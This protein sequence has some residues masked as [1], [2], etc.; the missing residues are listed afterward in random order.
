MEPLKRLWCIQLLYSLCQDCGCIS[1]THILC[2]V[3]NNISETTVH[4]STIAI[5]GIIFVPALKVICHAKMISN[6]LTKGESMI[7]IKLSTR[8]RTQETNVMYL[9]KPKSDCDNFCRKMIT[10]SSSIVWGILKVMTS[11]FFK[12]FD[13]YGFSTYLVLI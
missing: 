4:L 5:I 8:T 3:R 1:V 7:V 11:H 6:S 13:Y 12:P 10:S 2:L 9:L